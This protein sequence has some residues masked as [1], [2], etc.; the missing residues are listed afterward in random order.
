METENVTSPAEAVEVAQ[1]GA[2]PEAQP[3][4][5]DEPRDDNERA[6]A[7]NEARQQ[8]DG[9]ETETNA[10][11]DQVATEEFELDVAGTKHKFPKGTPIEQALEKVQAYSKGLEAELTRKSQAVAEKTKAVLEAEKV[12]Q[13]L[14]TL[15]FEKAKDIA[16]GQQLAEFVSSYDTPQG[17]QYLQQ[18]WQSNPDQARQLSDSLTAA[19]SEF[20]QIEARVRQ[21]GEELNRA[22]GERAKAAMAQT[23]QVVA[24]AIK[25]WSPQTEAKIVEYAVK[26]G[27]DPQ[28]AKD[29]R[30]A[31]PA[32]VL[33]VYKAMLWDEMQAKAATATKTAPAPAPATPI[34]APK[35][36]AASN[37]AVD[38]EKMSMDEYV[39]YME[40][41]EG[42]RK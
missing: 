24:K 23:E 21:Y 25:G 3:V 19:R 4:E 18:L 17:A 5:R 10:D 28:E 41:R 2:A 16:R 26:N 20:Q 9:V 32:T 37:R 6:N 12:V 7:A 33:A 31:N 36:K 11:G 42:R 30:R 39:A 8:A 34:A 13:R 38:L 1:G 22:E 29:W 35:A 27:A 14:Q 15:G 40:R